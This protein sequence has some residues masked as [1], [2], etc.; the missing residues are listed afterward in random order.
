MLD[1]QGQG[2][3]LC[4]LNSLIGKTVHKQ[5]T[6]S[7]SGKQK[8]TDGFELASAIRMELGSVPRH[9][10][11]SGFEDFAL[12]LGQALDAV[13]GNLV[14]DRVHFAADEFGGG[15]S[16]TGLELSFRQKERLA[17]RW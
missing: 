3:T 12:A 9:L 8:Q 7:G 11:A 10:C 17:D 4:S 13:G 2:W 1:T 16:S 15:R 6:P 14:E 5:D